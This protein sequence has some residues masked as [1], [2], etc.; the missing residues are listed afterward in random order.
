VGIP[1]AAETP[2]NMLLNK[3]PAAFDTTSPAA[4]AVLVTIDFVPCAMS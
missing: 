1:V 4:L 3:L 2:E